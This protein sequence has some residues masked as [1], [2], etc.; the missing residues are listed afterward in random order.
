MSSFLT[1][2]VERGLQKAQLTES[3]SEFERV[4]S[5]LP[6]CVLPLASFISLKGVRVGMGVKRERERKKKEVV[7]QS[8]FLVT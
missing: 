8:A 6:D 1:A 2:F 4:K 7:L 5:M 3:Q